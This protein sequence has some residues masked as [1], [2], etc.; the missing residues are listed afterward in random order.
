[1]EKLNPACQR[2][3]EDEIRN[4]LAGVILHTKRIVDSVQKIEFSLKRMTNAYEV[5]EG[6]I[7]CGNF[8]RNQPKD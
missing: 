6:E 2:A 1:M 5:L 3:F 8:Q 7:E 4:A